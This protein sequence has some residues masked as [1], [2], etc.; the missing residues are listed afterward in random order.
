MQYCSALYLAVF[1]P[2]TLLIYAFTS[3]KKRWLVLLIA[4][5]IFFLSLSGKL[6]VYLLFSTLSIHYFGL[7]LDKINKTRDEKLELCSKD[8]KKEIKEEYKKKSYKIV[9]FVVLIH[10]GLLVALKY[11]G[12][13]GENL[14][15]LLGV[16]GVSFR[17]KIPKIIVPIG[18]SF[19]TLQG[20][21]Y[22]IDVYKGKINA[23]DNLGRLALFM[24]FFPS[25]MEGPI[26]RYSDT[27]E[28]LYDG[29]SLTYKNLSFGAQ[30]ILWGLMKKMVIAD[31]LNPFIE[32]IFC[33]YSNLDG[34]VILIGAIFYTIQL[35]MDFSGTIDVVIGSAEMFGITLPENFRQPFFSKNISDF[36]TRWHITLGTWFRDYIFY[37]VSLSKPM[38]K[39]T[40]VSRK[41]LG[42]HYGPLLAG[43]IALFLVWIS[44][45]LWHGAA[46]TY[47]FF[48]MYHFVLI[49]LG[50]VFTPLIQKI[51]NKIH[52]NRMSK[53]YVMIQIVKTT[54]LVI[55]GELFFRANTLAGGFTMFKKIF[56]DF[57]L[58]SI[59]NGSLFKLGC[60]RADFLIIGIV[61]LIIFVSSVLK[62]KGINIREKVSKENIVVRWTLY[63]ILILIIIVFG[64]YG[65]GYA[66]VDPIYANF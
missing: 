5:Y 10:I 19:Y 31:R 55:F 38:K 53:P 35:Y 41:V 25:I 3:K 29:K 16:L 50:N 26:C 21:S 32:K 65:F 8:E 11:T 30:R 39:V 57:S 13:F 51:C 37:P 61:L 56:T 36:W 18:I 9:L 2:I 59:H 40:L 15:S 1:L 48:G 60:D 54:V 4:S 66:P 17:F 49:V 27:S 58:N 44:N 63:Y 62:E 33:E 14:N 22:I 7:W 28:A 23:D 24:A 47:V 45:G 12:F 46:W 6:I 34:G 64:A 42:N 43:S 20:L 52:V